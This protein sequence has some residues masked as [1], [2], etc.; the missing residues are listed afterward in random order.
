MEGLVLSVVM[1]EFRS[2]RPYCVHAGQRLQ[3][4]SERVEIHSLYGRGGTFMRIFDYDADVSCFWYCMKHSVI[5][6]KQYR[7][8]ILSKGGTPGII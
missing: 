1:H 7:S 4:K 3:S 5:M 8:C 6:T 2:L